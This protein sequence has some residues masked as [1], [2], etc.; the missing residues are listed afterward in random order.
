MQL[1]VSTRQ[2]KFSKRK[3]MREGAKKNPVGV[4]AFFWALPNLELIH[5]SEGV[6][7]L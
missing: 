2:K 1:F 3:L 7:P 6:A 5:S 4:W